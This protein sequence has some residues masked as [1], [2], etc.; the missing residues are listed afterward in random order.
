MRRR[1]RILYVVGTLGL[2][3]I[4]RLTTDLSLA[5]LC[6]EEWEPVICCLIGKQGHFVEILEAQGVRIEVCALTRRNIITFPLRFARLLQRLQ[7]DIVHSHVNHSMPWQVL[8]ARLA[9]VRRIIFT[10]H[11]EYQNWY[12]DRIAHLRIQSYFA[13]LLPFIFRYTTVSKAVRTH[14]ATMVRKPI[15]S[16][17]VV[18]N[19]VSTDRFQRKESIRAKVRRELGVTDT[20]FLVGS[21]A[22]FAEQKA[23]FCMLE[24]AKHVN[25]IDPSVRF[26]FVGD[27]P[28]RSLIEKKARDLELEN[29]VLLLGQRADI[30]EIYSALDAFILPSL[31]EGF[32]IALVEAMSSGLPIIASDLG[33]IAE[34][35]GEQAGIRI[36]PG[37]SKS[38]ARAILNLRANPTRASQ[39][40]KLARQRAVNHFSL[41]VIVE[42]YLQLYES[43]LKV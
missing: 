15:E 6:G 23:H 9:G 17:D 13:L 35:L 25:Q 11:N 32:P 20:I 10:Q 8:G 4:E 16:F 38:L 7:P 19:P 14:L 5:L 31:W 29:Q 43:A 42:Q 21:V 27:G 1:K 12:A 22:R 3:G 36:P 2:G 40:G 33:G 41:P 39:L 34:A 26:V 18:Y 24:A 28:L 37:D 30:H